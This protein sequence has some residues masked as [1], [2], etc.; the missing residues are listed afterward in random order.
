M[1][2]SIAAEW[3]SMG[4]KFYRKQEVYTMCWQNVDLSR[5]KVACAPFGGPIAIIRDDSKIVQLRAES[6]RPRLFIYSASGTLLAS[7]LWDRP[8]GRLVSL[9]WTDDE[10]LVCVVQDGTIFQYNIHGELQD[11][12]IAMGKECW[13]QGVAHCII[14][15]RGLVCI[16]E[17]N[18]L[19]AIPD[20]RSPK[21]QRLADPNL[22]E[23]PLCMVVIEPKPEEAQPHVEVL[24]AGT[25][26][27]L[28]VGIDSVQELNLSYGPIQKMA[29]DASGFYLA[30]FTFDGRLVVLRT[31]NY[32][33]VS[34]STTESALPPEQLTWC[35]SDSV[36]LYWEDRLLMVGPKNRSIQYDYE[37]SLVLVPECDGVRIVSNSCTEFLQLVPYS[38]VSVFKIGSTSP[39]AMLYDALDHFDR[40]SAKADE[41][42]RL[43]RPALTEAVDSCID[44]A[45]HEFDVGQQYTLLRAAAYGLPFCSDKR[46]PRNRFSEMCRTLRVLNAVRNFNIGIPLSIKQ[47]EKLT[48][49]K[50][51]F[52]L[53]NADRHL[54]A[55]RICEYLHLST[56]RVLTDWASK[57]IDSSPDLPDASLRDLLVAKLKACSMISYAGVA[58]NAYQM[59]R[60]KL[61]AMILDYEPQSSK[62]IPLLITMGE[63]ERA[64]LKA[65]ESG[66]TDLVYSVIFQIADQKN[67]E[68]FNRIILANPLARDLFISFTR[69]NDLEVLR[70]FYLSTGQIQG[71][72][73]TLVRESWEQVR[74]RKKQSLELG[75]S[76]QGHPFLAPRLKLLDQ[77]QRQYSNTK[78]HQLEA[79]CVGEHVKLLKIQH[80]LET[81]MG[82]AI[83]VD[84]SV[85]DTIC[86]CLSLGN[87]TAAEK[88]RSTFK[89]PIERFYLL[90]IKALSTTDNWVALEKFSLERKP[91]V[92]FKP[93]V[94]ACVDGGNNNEAMKYILKLSNLQ[95]KADAY[96][97]IGLHNEAAE[98]E[99][100]KDSG[101][102]L[103]RLK[104]FGQSTSAGNLFDNIRDRL[105]FQGGY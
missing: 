44:A 37:E 8:G 31:H 4:D 20:L 25:A 41:N 69:Q 66:D 91:P 84:S 61:T 27:V 43:I 9:G 35:G 62:Q 93:F 75:V 87:H 54:L 85:S 26:S 19:F 80:E 97:R 71:A 29:L 101:E 56:D 76:Q 104:F 48:V 36:L 77:A 72:A 79:N 53:L 74:K 73:E 13:D 17:Q 98:V 30:C 82:K 16:T 23:E 21:V 24:L 100:Q 40:R 96:R 34:D 50:L 95:E 49:S 58:E 28:K 57:K 102:L 52:R 12:H 89:V 7:I 2:V 88:L 94:D 46:F 60:H 1:A 70:Q 33:L 32:G 22:E 42:L 3:R 68:E 15:H 39:A 6:A 65:V 63:E 103:G 55:L 64:L 59:G 47:L 38:M 81:S 92:G 67:M 5:H 10:I 105:S 90:K 99:S 18:L 45:G 78:E 83:F 86:T 14:G 11:Q 51:I